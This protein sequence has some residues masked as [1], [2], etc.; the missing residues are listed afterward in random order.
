M[1]SFSVYDKKNSL[2]LIKVECA[3]KKVYE[4]LLKK[5]IKIKQIYIKESSECDEKI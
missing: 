1:R 4:I 5:F 2:L 3:N